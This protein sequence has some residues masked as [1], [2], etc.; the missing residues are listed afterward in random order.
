MDR[1]HTLNNGRKEIFT[2]L[3]PN[4]NLEH[5][6]KIIP[7]I[8][9]EAL[10]IHGQNKADA[11]LL[12]DYYYNKTEIQYKTKTQQPKINNMVGIPYANVAVTTINSYCFSTPFTRNS[13]SSNDSVTNMIKA[14]NDA[15]DDDSYDSKTAEAEFHAGISGLGYKYIRPATAEEQANGIWF[16]TVG[17]L[18]P[19]RTFCVKANTIDKPK[20]LACTYFNRKTYN[21]ETL[22]FKEETVYN[23]Y[24]QYHYWI[25]IKGNGDA[26]YRIE[27]QLVSRS[28]EKAYP[29]VYKKIPIIEYPR[30][31]DR[32]GD[33]EI[34]KS[35]I[36]SINNL[37][38][39]RVDDVQ[40][41]VDYILLLRDIAT[42]SE[43]DL[44]A[45]T[46]AVSKGILSFKSIQNA[47]V[48]PDVKVL[49]TKINQSEVQ[50]LQDF[51]GKKC[52][53][54]LN[55]PNRETRG[56]SGDT[57]TAVEN[58][59]GFRSLEN[60]AG[61]I[62]LSAIKAETESLETILAICK[63]MKGCPFAGLTIKD[64][65]IKA[66]RNKVEN[67]TTASNAYSTLISAGMNDE[68]A[69]SVTQIVADPIG[70]ANKNKKSREEAEQKALEL[71]KAESSNNSKQET[72][73]EES[74]TT[75]SSSEE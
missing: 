73:G 48:Q 37:A 10:N 41:A 9:D 17:D 75:D 15:L 60:I 40:Q 31:Q 38:S 49:D 62:T 13:R 26:E 46:K 12:K 43:A 14:F 55:I 51:L 34:G 53:E 35:I 8:L 16:K 27:E 65:Q 47:L 11:S 63:T 39:S 50:T 56:S 36:D 23:V 30:K 72:S 69:L 29:L 66:N 18:D 70:V 32:T 28:M 7:K 3:I 19:E 20:V 64:I 44:E 74:T 22:D 33:F 4:G 1:N 67:I 57:G 59:A 54:A 61:L 6:G 21:A 58:R 71:A 45:I 52:E 5:D 68:D 24:T 25:F 42:E 2:D